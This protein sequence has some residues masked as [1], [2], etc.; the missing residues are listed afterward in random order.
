MT[1]AME[2]GLLLSGWSKR[3]RRSRKLATSLKVI[4]R[5]RVRFDSVKKFPMAVPPGKKIDFS[6][7]ESLN[8]IFCG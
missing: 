1:L 3:W 8:Q 5:N 2:L 7:L 4:S 6:R